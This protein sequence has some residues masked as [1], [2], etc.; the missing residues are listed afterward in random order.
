METYLLGKHTSTEVSQRDLETASIIIVVDFDGD[1]S[2]RAN[3]EGG[4]R[5]SHGGGRGRVW[6]DSRELCRDKGSTDGDG[7][8]D[9]DGEMGREER[10]I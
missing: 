10:R 1:Q 2:V 3:I 7:E 4:S 5:G 6:G 8:G 9:G